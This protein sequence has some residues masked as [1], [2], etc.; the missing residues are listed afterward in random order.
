MI[1]SMVNVVLDVSLVVANMLFLF[2]GVTNPTFGVCFT[3]GEMG[4]GFFLNLFERGSSGD[5]VTSMLS[6]KGASKT[7]VSSSLSSTMMA[8]RFGSLGFGSLGFGSL[9]SL[10]FCS[11]VFFEASLAEETGHVGSLV[12]N[13]GSRESCNAI[14]NVGGFLNGQS[15]YH[16]Q[17]SK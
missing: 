8:L 15:R 12:F 3:I 11:F 7:A 4:V 13:E 9:G 14:S 2:D 6:Y 1:I 16:P 10:G 5:D 17:V